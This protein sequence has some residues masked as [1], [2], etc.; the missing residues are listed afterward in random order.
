MKTNP[1][2]LNKGTTLIETVVAVSILML[3]ISG[4]CGLALYA[5]QLSDQAGD[6]YRAVNIAK[7]RI[8]RAR[9]SDFALI[10]GFTESNTR[11]NGNGSPDSE[12]LYRRTT[13]VTEDPF[14]AGN[15]NLVQVA[16]Q[17]NILDR[18]DLDFTGGTVSLQTYI[19]R[20][21]EPES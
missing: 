17:V 12:G 8:E 13:T 10:T 19:A 20:Y 2:A 14:S 6:Q 9:N 3:F 15:S 4:I 5:K 21:M 11:V 7:N 1:T 16:V 18:K